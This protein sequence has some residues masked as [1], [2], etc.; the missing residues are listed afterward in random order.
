MADLGLADAVDAAEALLQPVRVPRQVII[1]HQV[2]ALEVD[3]FAG[4]I[5]RDHDQHV[6]VVHEGLDHLAAILTA[7][8]AV[9]LYHGFM[10]P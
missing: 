6:L 2:R 3:A 5:V 8:A 7:D 1:D 10:A 9:N 4:R